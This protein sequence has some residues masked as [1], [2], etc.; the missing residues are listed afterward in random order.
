MLEKTLEQR[1][2]LKYFQRLRLFCPKMGFNQR[3]LYCFSFTWFRDN[4]TNSNP[5]FQETRIWRDNGADNWLL[6]QTSYMLCEVFVVTISQ[7]CNYFFWDVNLFSDLFFS[8]LSFFLAFQSY[9]IS[10]WLICFSQVVRWLIYKLYRD[11]LRT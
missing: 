8:F 6:I 11:V 7:V 5:I 3:N 9:I 2:P 1:S 10:P 4:T